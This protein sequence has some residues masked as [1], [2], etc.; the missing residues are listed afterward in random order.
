MARFWWGDTRPNTVA[1]AHVGGER[2]GVV[3]RE[4]RGRRRSGRRP[5]RPARAATAATVRGLSPEMTFSVTSCS[6]K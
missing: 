6:A 2:V 5:A 4:L 3:G 1:S